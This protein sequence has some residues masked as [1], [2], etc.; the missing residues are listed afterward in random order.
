MGKK[1]PSSKAKNPAKKSGAKRGNP[2]AGGA[3]STRRDGGRDARGGGYGGDR[4]TLSTKNPTGFFLHGRHAIEAALNNPDRRAHCLYA[5]TRSSEDAHDLLEIRPD[6]DVFVVDGAE[7]DASVGSDSPHQG[8]LLDV[9]PL[10]DPGHLEILEPIKNQKN[11][12]LMLDQV[13]DPHNVGACMRSAAAL[14]ARAL[15]TQD[16]NAPEEGGVLARSSSGALECLPWLRMPNLSQVLENLRDMGYW[17][18]GLAGETRTEISQLDLGDNIIIVMGSEGKGLRPLVAKTC[19]TLARIPMTDK[20]ESLNV[21]NAAAIAL[22][23][24]SMR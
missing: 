23:E 4:R 2:N 3:H 24:V 15:I 14:G 8:L 9:E 18:V 20:I 16:R 19:D 10:S 1:K 5:T 21:S 13:T 6:L 7:M 11:I 17:S 22:Y 12:I